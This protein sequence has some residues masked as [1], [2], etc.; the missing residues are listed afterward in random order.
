[1]MMTNKHIL[2]EAEIV[3]WFKSIVVA[4]NHCHANRVCHRDIKP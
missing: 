3:E 4:L 2:E 1:M